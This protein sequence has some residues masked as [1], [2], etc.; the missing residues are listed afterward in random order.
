MSHVPLNA[1]M[2]DSSRRHYV[3]K[4]RKTYKKQWFHSWT[5]CY[6]SG[7]KYNFNADIAKCTKD[8]HLSLKLHMGDNVS[9][10]YLCKFI[11]WEAI[12][13][14]RCRA[15]GTLDSEVSV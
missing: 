8:T 13:W 1:K 9:S 10:L 3:G 15:K 6:A 12:M 11:K 5:Q 4:L 2:A 7:C 14:N